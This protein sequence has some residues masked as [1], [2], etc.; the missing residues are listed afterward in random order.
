VRVEEN[1]GSIV[2]LDHHAPGWLMR[3]AGSDKSR[4]VWTCAQSW[5]LQS[6]DPEL[7]AKT[8]RWLLSAPGAA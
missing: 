1:A 3:A 2:T 5:H 8:M 6:R 4:D 7:A